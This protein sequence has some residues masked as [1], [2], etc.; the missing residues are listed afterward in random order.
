MIKL[1]LMVALWLNFLLDFLILLHN[2]KWGDFLLNF[3][4]KLEV[5]ITNTVVSKAVSSI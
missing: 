5:S 3:I 2:A 1:I 4:N